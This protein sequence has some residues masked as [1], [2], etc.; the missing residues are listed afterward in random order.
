MPAERKKGAYAPLSK[1]FLAASV[2][3]AAAA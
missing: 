3:A 2:A 1:D